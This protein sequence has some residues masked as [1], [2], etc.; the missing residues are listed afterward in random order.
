MPLDR[1]QHVVVLSFFCGL[2]TI[3]VIVALL[4]PI[5]W[6]AVFPVAFIAAAMIDPG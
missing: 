1:K 3:L 2:L 6:L 4:D 5:V